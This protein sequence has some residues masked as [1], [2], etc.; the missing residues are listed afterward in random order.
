MAK[1][2]ITRADFLARAE[3]LKV[4]INDIPMTAET[5]EFSTG[6]F[7]WFLNAKTTI[8]VDGKPLSVQIGANF[9]VVGSKEAGRE[10][11]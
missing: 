6:S 10:P 7:G 9:T 8:V 2:S 11:A 4:L 3:P 5:K 1:C